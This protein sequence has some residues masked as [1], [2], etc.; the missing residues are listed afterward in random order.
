MLFLQ[1]LLVNARALLGRWFIR[2][3]EAGAA[4]VAPRSRPE[5]APRESSVSDPTAIGVPEE[6]AAP[7][8]TLQAQ[9]MRRRVRH[10]EQDM[11]RR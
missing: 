11:G 4:Q 7:P 9:L 5:A 8:S 1:P 6:C 10:F 3:C 2:P